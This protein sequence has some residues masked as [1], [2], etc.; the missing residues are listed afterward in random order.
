MGSESA[1]FLQI[2]AQFAKK[3]SICTDFVAPPGIRILFESL[4]EREA[5]LME[6]KKILRPRGLS[7][8]PHLSLLVSSLIKRIDSIII[9][10]MKDKGAEPFKYVRLDFTSFVYIPQAG[11]L[12]RYPPEASFE[13]VLQSLQIISPGITME[14]LR[15]PRDLVRFRNG[16]VSLKEDRT[17]LIQIPD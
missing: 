13:N 2:R 9:S 11:R 6:E 4:L 17:P 14:V 3:G 16:T 15:F 12:S 8:I 10:L 5:F 1:I 7:L